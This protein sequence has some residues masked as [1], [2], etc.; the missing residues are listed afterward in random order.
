MRGECV[1]AVCLCA[2]TARMVDLPPPRDLPL[3]RQGSSLRAS[4]PEDMNAQNRHAGD[5]ASN[6]SSSAPGAPSGAKGRTRT[7]AVNNV[8]GMPAI[9][10]AADPARKTKTGDASS[11]AVAAAAQ[12]Q[13]QQQQQQKAEKARRPSAEAE[14]EESEDDEDSPDENLSPEERRE[15]RKRQRMA[16]I[17]GVIF[18][19]LTLVVEIG[20]DE[21]VLMMLMPFALAFMWVFKH[22]KAFVLELIG[23]VNDLGPMPPPPP[24]VPPLVTVVSQEIFDYAEEKP[25]IY[26]L[27]GD[28]RLLPLPQG[29]HQHP[30]KDQGRAGTRTYAHLVLCASMHLP[31]PSPS[32]PSA[33]PSTSLLHAPP[34]SLLT[35]LP[36][37]SP[38]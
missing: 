21:T 20:L 30:R 37:A 16:M 22:V 3:P 9:A 12:Q 10:R 5:K 33:P 18:G 17:L 8:N 35:K 19:M 36:A 13:Q 26:L 24:T 34:P 14:E 7:S 6:S 23:E 1:V 27:H 38:N 15:L 4:S 28:W 31:T 29:H 25:V 32:E 11:A 2:H